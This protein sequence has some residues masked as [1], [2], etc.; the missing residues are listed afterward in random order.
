MV[1]NRDRL[2]LSVSEKIVA[3][4]GVI[5]DCE[6]LHSL[7]EVTGAFCGSESDTE[8]LTGFGLDS[9]GGWED[10]EDSKVGTQVAFLLLEDP[11]ESDLVVEVVGDFYFLLLAETQW[12]AVA[13]IKVFTIDGD[14]STWRIEFLEEFFVGDN[15]TGVLDR[16][17]HNRVFSNRDFRLRRV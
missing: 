13:K 17:L 7:E 11:V 14:K 9:G 15:L 6:E 8:G 10:V 2:L 12:T 1:H 4:L 16:K 5:S 3:F